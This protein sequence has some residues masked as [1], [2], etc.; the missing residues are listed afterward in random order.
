MN[1]L[2]NVTRG[3]FTAAG[4]V[5]NQLFLIPA[6]AL[7]PA[8]FNIRHLGLI[9][10]LFLKI[11]VDQND[12]VS[13]DDFHYVFLPGEEK[14]I[15]NPGSGSILICSDQE[16]SVPFCWTVRYTTAG[17]AAGSNTA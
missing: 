7:P 14:F 9:G 4:I 5:S 6:D 1:K 2:P 17:I 15:D 8:G 12:S 11:G 10:S 3:T 13:A 16:K